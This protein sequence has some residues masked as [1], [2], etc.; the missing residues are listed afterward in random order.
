VGF[1]DGAR[2]V[3]NASDPRVAWVQ[4]GAKRADVVWP[5]GY[6]ARFNPYLEILNANGE[7]VARHGDEIR[8]GCVTSE[9]ADEPL[10]LQPPFR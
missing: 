10:L 5:Q 1:P 8:G 2:L 7:I 4:F 6:R 3:G 9:S